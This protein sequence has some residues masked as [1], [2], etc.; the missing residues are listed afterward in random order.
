MSIYLSD[1]IGRPLVD[2]QGRPLGYLVDL[3]ARPI[4]DEEPPLL[5]AVVRRSHEDLWL[6]IDAVALLDAPRSR[7][8]LVETVVA[9]GPIRHDSARDLMLSRDL[10]DREVIDVRRRRVMR[11]NDVPL[12]DA[13]GHWVVRGVDCGVRVSRFRPR[14]QPSAL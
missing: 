8:I 13:A 7:L 6:P 10:L 12:D 3:V 14:E 11:V 5:G 1:V 2:A 4:G 9:L